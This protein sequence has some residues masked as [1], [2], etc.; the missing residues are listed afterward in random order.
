[1]AVNINLRLSDALH[2][3]LKRRAAQEGV[4]LN[5]WMITLLAGRNGI[6]HA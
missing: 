4:S 5:T 2:A 6:D 1:M 3:E